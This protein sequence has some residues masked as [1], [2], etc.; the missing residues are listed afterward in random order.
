MRKK[1]FS[2][3]SLSSVDWRDANQIECGFHRPFLRAV[4]DRNW[5]VGSSLLKFIGLIAALVLAYAQPTIAEES[6]VGLVI[7]TIAE[8]HA[9]TESGARYVPAANLHIGD[10]IFYT[11]RARNA[12]DHDLQNVVIIKAV[13]RNAR[14]VAET[15]AGPAASTS[16]S[17]DGGK[18]FASPDA[19]VVMEPGETTRIATT[20]DYTHIRWQLRYS[21]VAGATALL[22]FRGVFE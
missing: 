3:P 20:A 22:R 9:S 21:L 15:A 16:F 14:Y 4:P 18:S 13:P 19:L 11:L 12:T 6:S 17:V 10:E 8:I 5:L 7:E 2:V 1:F